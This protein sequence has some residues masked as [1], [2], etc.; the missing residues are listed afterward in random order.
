MSHNC[1]TSC[2]RKTGQR[3]ETCRRPGTL[4]AGV[5]HVEPPKPARKPHA[6][7]QQVGAAVDM[8][9]DGL[10]Y[11]RVAENIG[12]Y[13]DRPT[14]A[15]SVFNWVKKQSA[16]AKAV[17]DD[18]KVDT[19]PE[20]VADE[21]AVKLNGRQYWIFN[22]MDARTRFVLA[23]YLSPERTTRA[24]QTAMA[25]ARERSANPPLV[26][27]TDG[28]RSYREG[29]RNAFPTHPVKHVVSQGIRAEINNN[30]SER[31]QG[32]FRDRDKTLRGLKKQDSGQAYIDGLVLNYNYFRPHIGLGGKRPA[33]RAGAA[34]PF[35]SWLE[36]ATMT[37]DDTPQ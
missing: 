34:I 18:I 13:F 14:D 21:L 12:D 29:V 3:C 10:S 19:G 33:E 37:E 36:V 15:A 31:L 25:M 28:L 4:P 17:V 24:A 23:A 8:Y 9:Y 7:P 35:K 6:T 2:K 1:G 11:R 27:K 32:T 30:L 20:W 26:I 22:V 5:V 16:R